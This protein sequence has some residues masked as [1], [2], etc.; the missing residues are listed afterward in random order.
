MSDKWEYYVRT[1]IAEEKERSKT[2]DKLE[3]MMNTK[4]V[5]G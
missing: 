1:I 3:A 2:D 4:R 5:A